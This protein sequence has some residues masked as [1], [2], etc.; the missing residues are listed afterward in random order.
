MV[1]NLSFLFVFFFF[2]TVSLE[3]GDIMSIWFS[4]LSDENIVRA[5]EEDGE[6]GLCR[7]KLH[8]FLQSSTSYSPE[9]LLVQLR[10]D[11]KCLCFIVDAIAWRVFFFFLILGLCTLVVKLMLLMV[12]NLD[13]LLEC[14]L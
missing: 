12:L 3:N 1:K 6:L 10:Y 4:S 9:K 14:C 13:Y 2:L 8:K 5:G 11:C 7:R